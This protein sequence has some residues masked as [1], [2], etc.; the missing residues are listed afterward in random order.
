MNLIDN[1]KLAH[2]FSSIQLQMFASACDVVLACV[3]V[4]NQSWP[5]NP[6]YYVAVRL[7]MTV[8]AMGARLVA[9]GITHVDR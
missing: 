4:V 2:K 1:W 3:V 6:L 9:Q 8:A 7:T 5:I